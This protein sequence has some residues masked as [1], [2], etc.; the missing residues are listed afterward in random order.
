MY[1]YIMVLPYIHASECGARVYQRHQQFNNFC[2]TKGKWGKFHVQVHV[3]SGNVHASDC[4]SAHCNGCMVN[5]I[6]ARTAC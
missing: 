2:N 3:C 5:G 6:S 1:M 4:G